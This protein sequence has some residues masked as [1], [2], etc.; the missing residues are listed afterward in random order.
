M[1]RSR[2]AT[3]PPSPWTIPEIF[4]M[5]DVFILC[6]G[7][8]VT[9]EMIQALRGR[10]VIAVNF[11]YTVAQ[12]AP[13][14]FFA[15]RRF[16]GRELRERPHLIKSF[17]GYIVT[18]SRGIGDD[19]DPRFKRVKHFKPPPGIRRERD[20]V[21][22]ARTSLSAAINIAYH[23]RPARIVLVGADNRE[24][25]GGR[26]HCHDEYPWPRFSHSWKAKQ[27]ELEH[28]ANDLKAL[29]ITVL[30]ASPI[31]TLPFW[32][33]VDLWSVLDGR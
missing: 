12:F 9:P 29:G 7:T 25:P 20:S 16:W 26:A 27:Q 2:R 10:N 1:A 31:S 8:S 22:I 6:G 14:M 11:M 18:T 4:I 5:Q 3:Q 24:G 19:T 23:S 28:V 13:M 32:P 17:S 30:N 21:A 33:K 15:D